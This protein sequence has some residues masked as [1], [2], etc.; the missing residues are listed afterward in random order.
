MDHKH[1]HVHE[2]DAKTLLNTYTHPG[3]D[4]TLYNEVTVFPMRT[5]QKL[6]SSGKIS[7]TTLIDFSTG[8]NLSHLLTICDYFT[9]I[10]LLEPNYFCIVEVEKWQNG[11]EEAIDYS[12][13]SENF[14]EMKGDR[15]MWT[16]K[17]ETLKRKIKYIMRCD[18]K[19]KNPTEPFHLPKADCLMTLY[20]IGHSSKDK[21]AYC[22]NLRKL[23]SLINV[24][25]RLLLVGSFN[26]QFFTIGGDK[27][28]SLTIDE[29]F[30]RTALTDGGFTVE[31]LETLDSKVTSGIAKYDCLFLACALKIREV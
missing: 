3:M 4:E 5:L 13:L 31:H 30:L 2:F 11:E 23:S 17:E 28:H 22:E 12:H 19:K 9:D 6:L 24:G 16:E 26:I 14:P 29:D 20:L 18:L 10:I 27:F 8:P 25:G 15:K 21:E 7:G 1:Y